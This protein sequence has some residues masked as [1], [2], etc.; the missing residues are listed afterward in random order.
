MIQ[1]HLRGQIVQNVKKRTLHSSTCSLPPFISPTTTNAF[2][3]P[4]HSFISIQHHALLSFGRSKSHLVDHLNL[5]LVRI[6]GTGSNGTARF[7]TSVE[8]DLGLV[9]LSL[10]EGGDESRLNVGPGSIV[11]RLEQKEN[12]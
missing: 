9:M 6:L 10:L 8:W 3:P 5:L 11:E 12:Y 7:P 2:P 4:P 1:L